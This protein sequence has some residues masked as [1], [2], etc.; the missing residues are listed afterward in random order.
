[1]EKWIV[2]RETRKWKAG[3]ELELT[4]E[5]AA[6]IIRDIGGDAPVLV[7]KAEVKAKAQPDLGPDI[8]RIETR[9]LEEPPKDR[10]VKAAA[11]KR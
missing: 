3:Q 9:Q 6:W 10:Q 7:K 8:E 11:G 2:Q 5:E 1:M 4:D